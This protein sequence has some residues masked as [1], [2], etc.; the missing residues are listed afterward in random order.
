ME[1]DF[2]DPVVILMMLGY[3]SGVIP[4]I[5]VLSDLPF[6]TKFAIA[7]YG[8]AGERDDF[9]NSWPDDS[10]PPLL[11]LRTEENALSLS[12]A[13]VVEIASRNLA[14]P[15]AILLSDGPEVE[16]FAAHRRDVLSRQF[17]T[18]LHRRCLDVQVW[19]Y[20]ASWLVR[21]PRIR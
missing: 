2:L 15:L 1:S 8:T 18:E 10:A 7:C 16:G 11:L 21:P 9:R 13:A 6:R 14:R 12:V 20:S 3:G 17:A 19:Q 5:S 4:C